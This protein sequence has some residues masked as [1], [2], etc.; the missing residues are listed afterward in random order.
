MKNKVLV[1]DDF[2]G[3]PLF[4]GQI[5]KER[6]VCETTDAKYCDDAYLKIKKA[7][8]DN[9]P[10]NLLISDL[11]FKTDYRNSKLNSGEEL[12]SAIKKLQPDIKIIVFSE[13]IKSFR[14][15]SLFNDFKINAFVY[16][17]RNSLSE[18][19]NALQLVLDENNITSSSAFDTLSYKPL[20][21]ISEYDVTLLK[22]ASYG[23]SLEEIW[24]NLKKSGITPHSKSSVEK[25]INKLRIQ[26]KAKNSVHLIAIAKDMGLI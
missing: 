25:N 15:K 6:S 17:G 20:V 7:I 23:Y 9:V 21:Q 24:K 3:I 12:I 5:L 1:A 19:E 26:F 8:Y 10:Y 22:L 4:V 18:L 13:E 16:K 2:D 11:N 14:I